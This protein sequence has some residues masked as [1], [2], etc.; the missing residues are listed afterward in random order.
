MRV[1]TDGQIHTHR[2]TDAKWFYNLSSAIY[3]SYGADK[4]IMYYFFLNTVYYIECQTAYCCYFAPRS[5]KY[6][7][8]YV[9]LCVFMSVC[10]HTYLENEMAKGQG[11]RFKFTR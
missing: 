9:G 7:D 4:N 1:R 2:R 10:P 3:Y 11:H 5:A 6:C 8:E